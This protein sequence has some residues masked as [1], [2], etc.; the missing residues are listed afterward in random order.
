MENES[1]ELYLYPTFVICGWKIYFMLRQFDYYWAMMTLLE[2]S[3]LYLTKL[4]GQVNWWNIILLSNERIILFNG[5][6][7]IE[8]S[9][10]GR[11]A[12]CNVSY[13][14]IQWKLKVINIQT[15]TTTMTDQLGPVLMQCH[16]IRAEKNFNGNFLNLDRKSETTTSLLSWVNTFKN[17]F[18]AAFK[19]SR[20]CHINVGFE[21]YCTAILFLCTCLQKAEKKNPKICS[22]LNLFRWGKFSRLS[23]CSPSTSSTIEKIVMY[24]IAIILWKE[25]FKSTN[26]RFSLAARRERN[27]PLM[28]MLEVS[29]KQVR[30]PKWEE[31]VEDFEGRL[32]SR[33]LWIV[34]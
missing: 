1:L 31:N 8:I 28:G 12:W 3:I 5:S 20:V 16:D 23:I 15:E 9:A 30:E 11:F 26:Y 24:K 7:Q 32:F 17:E 10:V 14:I 27:K 4:L 33:F 21:N 25:V 2:F 34:L 19:I 22:L 29:L 6:F 13:Y 18:S